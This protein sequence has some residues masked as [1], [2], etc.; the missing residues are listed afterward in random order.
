MSKNYTTQN[1]SVILIVVAILVSG[2]SLTYITGLSSKI[3]ELGT[4]I[5]EMTSTEA[6]LT[7]AV[8]AV[9]HSLAGFEESIS[10]IEKRLEDIEKP[11][12]PAEKVVLRLGLDTAFETTD[13]PIWYMDLLNG[14]GQLVTEPLFLMMEEGGQ[15]VIKPI[16][17]ESWEQEDDLT[18]V[19]HLKHGVKFSDGSELTSE[20]VWY[21][22][23]GRQEMRPS[24]MMW[25]IDARV[26][27]FEI[28]DDYTFKMTTKYPMP[29]LHAWLVQGWT[30]IMSYDQVKKSHQEDVYPITGI[31]SVLGTGPYM[32]TE[33]EP[34]LYAKMTLNPYYCGETP[35]ITDI[36][37][38]YIPDADARVAALETNTVDFIHQVPL[39]ALDLLKN[40]GFTIWEAPGTAFRCLAFNNMKPPL[41]D[42]RVRKALAHA[43]NY[44]EL[45]DTIFAGA[46]MH[47]L[48]VVPPACLGYKEFPLY[49]Y[50][51]V[52]AKELLADAG[53]A[54]GLTLKLAY[55]EGYFSHIGECTAVIQAYFREV[56]VT[57]DVDLL[58]RS[59]RLEER[60]GNRDRYLAGDMTPEEMTYD[61]VYGGWLTD[62]LWAGDDLYSL[63]LSTSNHNYWYIDNPEVD[64]L[65]KFSVSMAPLEERIEAAEKVQQILMEDCT[66]ISFFTS[67]YQSASTS[68][69]TGHQ[70]LPNVYEYFNEGRLAK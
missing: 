3:D 2:A 10:E 5:E 15:V 47:P 61:I 14:V 41:D 42:I 56:G 58:E 32:W 44:D 48:S 6:E 21:S 26:D 39:E 20:D 18:W 9:G 70:I 50:D 23:W 69:Y 65:I 49:D 68:K 22:I 46:A 63:Y 8:I 59:K 1:I 27:D 25:S 45:I 38:Y 12:T 13:P 60:E 40:K 64:E 54:D 4:S 35:Q 36:E 37:V 34:M 30:Q 7:D 53:Y 43:I 19:F 66:M 16:L 57:L 33:L 24:N 11:V 52:K 62:T 28:V 29:N 17:V 55:D 31:D 51:P 67:P